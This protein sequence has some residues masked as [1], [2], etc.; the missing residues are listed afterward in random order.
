MGVDAEQ[1]VTTLAAARSSLSTVSM[2]VVDAAG[3]QV[4]AAY[5][6]A[7]LMYPFAIVLSCASCS[8]H[9]R[10]VSLQSWAMARFPPRRRAVLSKVKQS[11]QR[12]A[13]ELE[14]GA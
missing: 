5:S 1:P 9:H 6:S 10:P 2:C 7:P 13:E 4:A 14:G 8:P 11:V 12:D 3:I